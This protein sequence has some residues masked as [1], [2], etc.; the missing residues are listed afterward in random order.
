LG[1]VAIDPAQPLLVDRCV[2]VVWDAASTGAPHFVDFGVGLQNQVAARFE[3]LPAPPT[4]LKLL[5]LRSFANQ[6]PTRLV[7]ADAGMDLSFTFDVE[8]ANASVIFVSASIVSQRGQHVRDLYRDAQRSAGVRPP[9]FAPFS[10]PNL[11]RWDGRDD[12]GHP[13][14][15]GIYVL[16]LEAGLS[17]GSAD[18]EVRRAV[19]VVR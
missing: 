9:P 7:L 10:D 8:P 13:V 12:G 17:P 15:G 2:H 1:G 3:P 18:V 6:T 14:T 5:N 19:S 11:D 16:R 4:Y